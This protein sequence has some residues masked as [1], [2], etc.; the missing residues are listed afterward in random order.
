M[1][2]WQSW[3]L[4]GFLLAGPCRAGDPAPFDFSACL[5]KMELPPESIWANPPDRLLWQRDLWRR[6]IELRREAERL[7]TG[8]GTLARRVR[9]EQEA[10]E[11]ALRT[12]EVASL[13]AL[14]EDP[15]M[16][17]A[18]ARYNQAIEPILTEYLGKQHDV[19]A[20]EIDRQIIQRIPPRVLESSSRQLDPFMKA[21]WPEWQA[22][23]KALVAHSL[24]VEAQADSTR[25]SRPGPVTELAILMLEAQEL[26]YLRAAAVVHDLL[27][28]GP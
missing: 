7:E 23:R 19:V 16:R 9:S 26:S 20:R 25:R 21:Y 4:C 6:R 17:K 28:V 13:R 3:L 14:L 2:M 22:F 24:R 15:D 1:R 5:A 11:L 12:P 8:K 10:S 27:Y 18:L